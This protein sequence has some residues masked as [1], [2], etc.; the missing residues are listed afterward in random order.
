M[1]NLTLKQLRYFEA[2]ARHNH[3]GRAADAC[4]ISQPAISVQIRELEETLGTELFQRGPRQVRLTNFG[5]EFALRVRDILRSVDELTDLARASRDRLV[6][7]LRIGVIPTIAPYLLPAIIGNLARMHDGLD[8][9]VRETQTQKLIQE[10]ADGRLDAAIV[11]L[12]VSEPSLT[13]I[14]LFAENFVLVR[15]GEDEGKPVPNREMLREMRLL[16]LEEG[17]CFRDQALSFCN[18]HSA[19]PRELLDGSS[20]STL[21]QMVG[22]GVGVTLIPEMAVPVETRSAAV[23]VAHF[24]NPQPSRTIGMIWRKTSPI[25]KQLMLISEVVRQAAETLRAQHNPA[26]VELNLVAAA[27]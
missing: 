15:P 1:T 3:F 18:M 19:R 8:I 17:H 2:L 7:R 16:L 5:E 13:E 27:Q 23:S 9:H 22:A 26:S 25:A 12:P 14:V 10:L 4:S 11:A 20:L 21:V 24:A 6:G